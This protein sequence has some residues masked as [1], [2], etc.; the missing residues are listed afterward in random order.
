MQVVRAI[1]IW[2][3]FCLS[4]LAD[5][6]SIIRD[7]EIEAVLTDMA[8]DLF[9]A[10]GLN[11]K[12]AKVYVI[13]SDE[14]NAFTIGGGY[15][16]ITSGLLIKYSNPL[17]VL[18]V[19]AHET[20]HIAAGHVS[21]QTHVIEQH[22]KFLPLAALAGVLGSVITGSPE[23]MTIF[24][25]CAMTSDR[26]LARYSRE[27]ELAADTLSAIYMNKLGYGAQCMIDVLNDFK[28]IEII[29]GGEHIPTYIRSHPKP[30]DRMASLKSNKKLTIGLG[31]QS[32]KFDGPY[33]RAVDKIKMFLGKH[34]TLPMKDANNTEYITAVKFLVNGRYQD[35]IDI[36]RKLTKKMPDDVYVQE[37]LAQALFENGNAK[38]AV[39]VYERIYKNDHPLIRLGY[40]K[41]LIEANDRLDIAIKLLITIKNDEIHGDEVFHWLAKAYAKQGREG[42]ADL[43]LAYEQF[44]QQNFANANALL[45]RA[46]L[47]LDN[48][49]DKAY[50]KQSEDLSALLQKYFK[51]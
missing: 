43:M 29:S 35:A 49:R 14:I 26:L 12:S 19:M 18:A 1:L 3:C 33:E 11:P 36:L 30:N 34:S 32:S 47:K 37:T 4:Q 20:G 48:V 2:L 44:A 50:V 28:D 24:L 31:K 6:I 40:A 17:N 39:K 7:T 9:K 22:S 42:V 15:I 23:A 25:G 13:N 16:F 27:E 5:A 51:Q 10:A 8:Q 38:E 41:A 45:K 46:Q 21:K